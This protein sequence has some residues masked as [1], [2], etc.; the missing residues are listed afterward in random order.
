MLWLNDTYNDAASSVTS[1]RPSVLHQPDDEANL[2][3][4]K[5]C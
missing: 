1:P 5:R 4:K 2:E 3:L